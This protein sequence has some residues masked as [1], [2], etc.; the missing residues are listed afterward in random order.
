MGIQRSSLGGGVRSLA[1]EY[2]LTLAKRNLLVANLGLKVPTT[3]VTL[4]AFRPAGLATRI[5]ISL[6]D[7]GS[8][9]AAALVGPRLQSTIVYVRGR[10]TA[11]DNTCGLGRR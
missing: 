7:P 2:F 11:F 1:G 10:M 9:F 8:C 4:P 5:S 6:G 3:P